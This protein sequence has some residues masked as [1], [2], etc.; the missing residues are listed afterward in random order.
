VLAEQAGIEAQANRHGF[1]RAEAPVTSDQ[2]RRFL[3]LISGRTPPAPPPLQNGSKPAQEVDWALL[4]DVGAKDDGCD[5]LWGLTSQQ[6]VGVGTNGRENG[7]VSVS[8]NYSNDT[9]PVE[10]S[11]PRCSKCDDPKEV[12]PHDRSY[13]KTHPR[14]RS[15]MLR[16]H[17]PYTCGAIDQENGYWYPHE[18]VERLRA[19]GEEMRIE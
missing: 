14:S 5:K 3:D 6:A 9:P 19:D 15:A 8:N 13:W 1:I 10:V 11:G 12:W 16:A 4:L 17:Q 7:V 2:N 18:Y